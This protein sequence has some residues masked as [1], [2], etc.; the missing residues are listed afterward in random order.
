LNGILGVNAWFGGCLTAIVVVAGNR[1][2]WGVW[3][4]KAKMVR[5]S[6]KD[7]Y[8]DVAGNGDGEF[9]AKSMF[10]SKYYSVVA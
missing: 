5:F 7:D 2:R 10:I 9:C 4:K 8:N 3:G 1:R 6:S